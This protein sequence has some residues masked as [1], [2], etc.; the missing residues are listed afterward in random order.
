MTIEAVLARISEHN[1]AVR[2]VVLCGQGWQ[3]S[4][5]SETYKTLNTEAFGAYGALLLATLDALEAP[6]GTLD[7]VFLDFAGHSILARRVD[8]AWVMLLMDPMGRGGFRKALIGLKI[9]LPALQEALAGGRAAPAALPGAP[10]GR[11]LRA[12]VDDVP[13]PRVPLRADVD[14]DLK[15]LPKVPLRAP[16]EEPL[17]P[18]RVPLRLDIP[19]DRA[20]GEKGRGRHRRPPDEGA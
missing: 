9:F 12:P 14:G 18:A 20:P 13:N 19:A 11:T 15:K 17:P 16:V 8:S 7:T 10:R 1:H 2:A 4:D 5:L 3:R 6:E